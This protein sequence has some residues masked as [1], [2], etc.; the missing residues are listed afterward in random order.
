VD[1]QGRN[2]DADAAEGVGD[3]V[4]EHAWDEG[5]RRRGHAIHDVVAVGLVLNGGGAVSMSTGPIVMAVARRG[6]MAVAMVVA[7]SM[8]AMLEGKNA[9]KI[10]TQAKNRNQKQT[11]SVDVRWIKKSLEIN[12][13]IKSTNLKS[14]LE[15]EKCNENKK[16][17][18]HKSTKHFSTQISRYTLAYFI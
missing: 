1:E 15:D 2:D 3:D 9:N 11:M 8:A 13:Q 4:E 6:A 14:L 16:E 7:V 18:I 5:R 17:G 12:S 10:D